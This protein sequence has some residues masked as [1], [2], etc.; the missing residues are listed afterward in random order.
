MKE[1]PMTILKKI[2]AMQKGEITE[3]FVYTSIA[4]G[5]KNKDNRDILLQIAAQE[6]AHAE[7]WAKYT[8]KDFRPKKIKV[9]FYK[10]LSIILGYTFTLKI[11]ERGEERAQINYLEI[12]EY[13][14]DALWIAREEDEHEAK[15]IQMLDEERLNYVGSMVLGLN[16]AL[17][18]LTGALA[19]LTF[20][21]SNTA[22]ISLSGLITGIAASLSMAASEYLSAKADGRDDA[23]KSAFYTGTAYI[24]TVAILILPYLLLPE[25]RFL[26]LG[27]MLA[28]VV[29][30]IF[31]F[32]YYISVAKDLPFKKRFFQMVSISLGVALISFGIG[33][34]IKFFLGIDV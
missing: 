8:K 26:A 27:I 20:A 2:E 6:R 19:G 33:L 23:L 12:S 28:S 31:I 4:K 24:I 32:N 29:L 13:V 9:L 25:N 15:L 1:I 34:A 30:I 18:E 5:I 22:I 16:D 11:M 17:V 14:E 21:L 10:I 3:Y 7:I